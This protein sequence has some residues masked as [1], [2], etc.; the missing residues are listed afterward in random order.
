M[1]LTQEQAR[2]LFDY[3]PATGILRW[4]VARSNI[5]KVGQI[6]GCINKSL[7]RR[8]VI[9]KMYDYQIAWVWVHGEWPTEIDHVDRDPLNCRIANL[10][11]ATSAQNK[12]NKPKQ[13]NNKSGYK[14]VSWDKKNKQ[15]V[16]QI[17]ICG[18]QTNLG[19]FN[20]IENAAL[21]YNFAAH[22]HFGHFAFFNKAG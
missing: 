15:W 11:L 16:A 20:R 6:A 12:F 1:K 8:V 18:R 4:R 19:R 14:G 17:A 13:A 3:D 7:N 9:G 21:A 10:R 2:S 5:V 22:E